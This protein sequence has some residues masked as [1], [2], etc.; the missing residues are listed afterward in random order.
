[1]PLRLP[2]RHRWAAL[3]LLC[4]GCLLLASAPARAEDE[5]DVWA[6]VE[7]K[8]VWPQY[9]FGGDFQNRS[10]FDWTFAS[11]TEPVYTS[12][13]LLYI[14]SQVSFSEKLSTTLSGLGQYNITAD[15]YGRE[16]YARYRA[17]LEELYVDLHLG[18]VDLRLGQQIV[19]WGVT[20]VFTPTDTI[21][22]VN[23]SVQIDQELGHYKIPNLMAKADYYPTRNHHLEGIFI[24]FFR[25][26]SIDISGGD[27]SV[28]GGGWSVF[29]S[30]FPTPFLTESLGASAFGR[31]VLSL[32]DRMY[33]GWDKELAKGLSS[34]GPISLGMAPP[35][36][37]LSHWEAA[38]RYGLS[39]GPVTWSASYFY[40]FGDLPTLYLSPEV[41]DVVR[42]IT[43]AGDAYSTGDFLSDAL[44]LDPFSLLK[45][46]YK[47]ANQFGTDFS[48]N[49]GPSVLRVEGTYVPDR[50]TY[51]TQLNVVK[52]PQLT[53]TASADYTFPKYI[54]LNGQV[55]HI[56]NPVWRD[57]VLGT[58]NTVFLISYLHGSFL[59]DTL[60]MYL[61]V[62]Y[63][64]TN[65]SMDRWR[66]GEIF[67]DGYE[68]SGKISYQFMPDLWLGVGSF[69]F[70]GP[71]L[72]L[73]GL[74]YE[75]SF[76]FVDLK[77]SF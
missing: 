34:D 65:W 72:S 69:N 15:Q 61:E 41:K 35:Y 55:L 21:N 30:T 58:Q 48:A 36:D 3:W 38:F 45:T 73:F 20:D 50:F 39:Y 24:P 42:H 28:L 37:D 46:E 32:L 33:P 27:W 26:A 71:P 51:D 40:G 54:I 14:K 64:G 44:K 43:N 10:T 31:D 22:S 67:G 6:Q 77:Y 8:P 66:R 4:C 23:Y 68:F 12:R 56:Y 2:G 7:S 60:E 74:L 19:T 59:D 25:P 70:N 62:I 75:K 76:G 13:E 29:G 17:D 47:R 63:D 16:R 9:S 5:P 57:D 52:L 1:L 53:Y 18:K 49:V 11:K